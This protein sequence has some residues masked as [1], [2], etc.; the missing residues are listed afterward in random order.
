MSSVIDFEDIRIGDAISASIV[1]ADGSNVIW[2][3]TV[4]HAT[5]HGYR[6]AR[7][8]F[9]IFGAIS[10]SIELIHREDSLAEKLAKAY[11]SAG[12]EGLDR[13]ARFRRLVDDF[14]LGV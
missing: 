10:V 3:G 9:S 13:Y 12:M 8:G 1:Y 5:K 11:G 14:S 6:G 7:S 4:T 2:G